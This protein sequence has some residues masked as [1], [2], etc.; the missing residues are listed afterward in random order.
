MSSQMRLRLTKNNV[1]SPSLIFAQNI[2]SLVYQNKIFKKK[3]FRL[4]EQKTQFHSIACSLYTKKTTP[5]FNVLFNTV[6][7]PSKWKYEQITL[8]YL[9]LWVSVH[10]L[11]EPYINSSS[12]TKFFQFRFDFFKCNVPI[13]SSKMQ[14]QIQNCHNDK[15]KAERQVLGHSPLFVLRPKTISSCDSAKYLQCG[16]N[17]PGSLSE[18]SSMTV[19]TQSGNSPAHRMLPQADS[20]T[21]QHPLAVRA[22]RFDAVPGDHVLSQSAVQI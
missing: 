13:Q 6:Q 8:K 9:W 21:Y 5:Q 2:I 22:E 7:L 12:N 10:S 4:V 16:G 11:Y 18:S 14:F 20:S 1:Y 17:L 15:G 19:N 3:E